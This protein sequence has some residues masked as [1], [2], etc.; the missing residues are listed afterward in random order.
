MRSLRT[1]RRCI[2]PGSTGAAIWK[3]I[4]GGV[5]SDEVVNRLCERYPAMARERVETDVTTF[6]SQ[7][8]ARGLVTLEAAP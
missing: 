1:S 8:A 5:S 3:E 6:L 2:S 7:L 4:S